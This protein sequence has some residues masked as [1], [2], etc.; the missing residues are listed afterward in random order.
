MCLSLLHETADVIFL[1][2]VSLSALGSWPSDNIRS[3]VSVPGQA[4]DSPVRTMIWSRNDQW[5]VTGDHSGY[6]K[7]WQMN[8]NNVKMFQAHKDPVRGIR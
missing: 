8:M 3:S 2:D 4:H 1:G 6:I 7:Y 5:M